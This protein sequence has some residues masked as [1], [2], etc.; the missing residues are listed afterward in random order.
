MDSMIRQATSDHFVVIAGESSDYILIR[1][2]VQELSKKTGIFYNDDNLI[3]D[4]KKGLIWPPDT[5]GDADIYAGSYFMRR[6]GTDLGGVNFLS[7]EMRDW[8]FNVP[9]EQR[10]LRMIVVAGIY[11]DTDKKGAEERLKEIKKYCPTAYLRKT[12]IYMGCIH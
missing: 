9:Y 7:L 10:S 3:Y 8:Y 11:P 1:Q 5:S 6:Y 12:A 2:S 4:R